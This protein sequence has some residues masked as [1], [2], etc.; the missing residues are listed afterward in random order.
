MSLLKTKLSDMVN[1]QNIIDIYLWYRK[2]TIGGAG[3]W[4]IAAACGAIE[5]VCYLLPCVYG[6]VRNLF[7]KAQWLYIEQVSNIIS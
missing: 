1:V 7:T 5:P 4:Y 2:Q 6:D 3:V